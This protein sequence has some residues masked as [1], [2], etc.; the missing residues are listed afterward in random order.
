MGWSLLFLFAGGLAAGNMIKD[1]GAAQAIAGL[2][3]S[4]SLKGGLGTIL[5]IV[6]FTS[7]LSEIS[8]NTAAAAI[9][10]PITV[11]LT[12]S[13]RLDPI[14]YVFIS[15]A[16]FNVAHMLPTSV[17]AIPV[18]H[19]LT[20]E[21]LFKHGVILT[22]ANILFISLAGYLMLSLYTL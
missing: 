7:L 2:L 1:S 12:Q 5:I 22:L 18:G 17:R 10:V 19:G 6:T 3:G 16:A 20:T 9:A 13:L 14:P 4:M 8:S 15:I 21:Y 11:S